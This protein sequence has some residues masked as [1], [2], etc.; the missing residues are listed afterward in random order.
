MKTGLDESVTAQH[1]K[2]I[3]LTGMSR[4]ELNTAHEQKRIKHCA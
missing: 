3:I 2:K 4:R 1:Q